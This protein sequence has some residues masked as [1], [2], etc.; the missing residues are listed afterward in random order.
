MFSSLELHP[1][2]E[3][4]IGNVTSFA[5]SDDDFNFRVIA[6]V[7]A[8]ANVKPGDVMYGQRRGKGAKVPLTV[9]TRFPTPEEKA[10]WRQKYS[11][12]S[13]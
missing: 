2:G 9:L 7:D 13:P 1:K 8:T 3:S 11:S 10:A 6:A 12:S 4:P 5:F